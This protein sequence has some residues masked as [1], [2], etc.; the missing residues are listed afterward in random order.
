MRVTDSALIDAFLRNVGRTRT[1]IQTLHLQ[2]ASQ[3]R[4][5][6]VSDNP[7]GA[8]ALMRYNAQLSRIDRYRDTAAYLG[9]WTELATGALESVS[10]VLQEVKSIVANMGSASDPEL[11][12]TMAEK[13]DQLIAVAL[14]GA[15]A[16]LNGRS[17][18]GGTRT[19]LPAYSMPG[20]VGPA[21]YN[22]TVSPQVFRIGDAVTQPVDT[23]GLRV[24][25]STAELSITG[26]LDVGAP[27]GSVVTQSMIVRD[28][29][30]VDHTIDARFE[31]TGANTWR[32]T[33]TVPGGATD[34]VITGGD[35][36][37]SF[38]PV[39]G[40]VESG[41]VGGSFTLEPQGAGAVA[42]PVKINLRF[43]GLTEGAASAVS[44][45]STLYSVFDK[46]AELRDRLRSGGALTPEDFA[47]LE[48][49]Q[50][51][52]LAEEA[53]LGGM[54]QLVSTADG[55][56]VRQR[57]EL[58]D[59]KDSLQAVDLTEIGLRLQL[60]QTALEAALSAASRIVPQ[61]LLDFLR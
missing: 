2:L 1:R 22:G 40:A 36:V 11:R 18:F 58:L 27:A 12:G 43:E 38:D 15:N 7:S 10:G 47:T 23:N 44:G 59:L 51:T 32:L 17:L 9:S 20:G 55:L 5:N 57:E 60:E 48:L 53:S 41:R 46:L 8:V 26:S 16:T 61:S 37:L 14:E 35:A 50:Q 6:T 13:L 54:K 42:P 25:G 33:Y 4:I 56:L 45:S 28:G 30:G 49:M 21:T 29:L 3:Q 24:F 34:A 19:D 39:T 52:V 31:K